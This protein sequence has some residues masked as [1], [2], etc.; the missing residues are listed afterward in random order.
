MPGQLTSVLR[1]L[2]HAADAAEADDAALLQRFVARRDEDAFAALLQRHGPLVLAVCR[3]AL[4][5]RADAEDAFQATFLVLARKAGSIR[6]QDALAAWLHRVALNISRTI[7]AAAARR[8]AHERQ[9]ADMAQAAPS[10]D[11]ELRD[12][13]SVLHEEVDQLPEKHRVPVVLCYL[14]GLTHEEAARHLGWPV[15]S[16]KGRLARARERLRARLGHRGLTLTGAALTAALAEGAAAAAPPALLCL[17]FR[18]AL[19]FAAGREVVSARALALAKGALQTMT[20]KKLLHATLV[21]LAVG[22]FGAG[23]GVGV[24]FWPG[25]GPG[26]PARESRE[27]R[28]NAGTAGARPAPVVTS[29]EPEIKVLD[30]D[31]AER[32]AAERLEALIKEDLKKLEGTWHMVACEEGGKVLAPERTNPNDFFTF[33]GTTIFFKSG[34]RGARGTFTIDPSKNPKWMDHTFLNGKQVLKGIYELKGD[35]LRVLFGLPGGERPAELRTKAGDKLW[36]RTFERVKAKARGHARAVHGVALSADGKR[37]ATG[38]GDT[39]AILWD[40]A[41]GKDLQV[42][43]G[44]AQWVFSVALSGDGKKLLTGSHDTTAALWDT[45]TAEKLQTFRGHRAEVSSVAL[46]VDGKHV[47]TGSWDHTAILWDAAT[48]KQLQT[49]KGHR[50]IVTSVALSA[51]GKR[52]VTG[53]TDRT[54][55]LWEVA[56]GK[57]CQTFNGHRGFVFSVSLSADGKRLATGSEDRTAILWDVASGERRRVFSGGHTGDVVSVALSGN[58]K[59]LATG[60]EDRTA[61]LWD[62]ATGKP[63][64]DFRGHTGA[65]SGVALSADAGRLATGSYDRSAILWG[66]ATGKQ[67]HAFQAAG[68]GAK[69]G[70]A[71]VVK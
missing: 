2:R 40:T 49:F 29:N 42:F 12:W 68:T 61:V 27:P 38:S 23:A 32:K 44:H 1:F 56:G 66:A 21:L 55:I 18:S 14:Q 47:L 3:R 39:T 13:Q 22:L 4:R 69:A 43:K 19:A 35:R 10:D 51:D 34:L 25:T 57:K 24:G 7:K 59:R 20:A 17:T 50:G 64:Q 16:V 9:V 60:S 54:A 62:A 46:S 63:C 45:A 5:Q 53:S 41:S 71:P 11:V 36:L 37:L 58:G 52:V 15:G 6:Q 65:V 8:Q 26:A 33:K 48:G 31:A 67:L 30:R 28:G 70:P